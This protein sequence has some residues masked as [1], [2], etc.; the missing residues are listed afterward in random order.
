MPNKNMNPIGTCIRMLGPKKG[1]CPP[2]K[3]TCQST[4]ASTGDVG[5][6]FGLLSMTRN[7]GRN[8]PTEKATAL[9][10]LTIYITIP[11]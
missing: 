10:V 8:G 6:E 4:R 5:A 1:Y 9:F 2:G 3:D 11:K 7:C